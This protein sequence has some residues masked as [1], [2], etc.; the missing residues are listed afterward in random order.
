M[1]GIFLLH[2]IK[3][4]FCRVLFS[5]CEAQ[6]RLC[7]I[8]HNPFGL[9]FLFSTLHLDCLYFIFF[10]DVDLWENC[11]FSSFKSIFSRT[12]VYVKNGKII[13]AV[14]KSVQIIFFIFSF[15]SY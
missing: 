1:E 7:A 6:L 12:L 5:V 2:F 13:V 11:F 4:L 14:I 10:K 15:F 8:D 9:P 3:L